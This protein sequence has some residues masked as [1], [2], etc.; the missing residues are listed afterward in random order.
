[1]I[2]QEGINVRDLASYLLNLTKYN[3]SFAASRGY[4]YE[5]YATR[6][7]Q[8]GGLFRVKE[9]DDKKQTNSYK[10]MTFD[11]KD[12]VDFSHSEK[13][14]GAFDDLIINCTDPSK[15]YKFTNSTFPTADLFNPPNNF[16][17]YTVS[18]SHTISKKGALDMCHACSQLD[19]INLYFVIPDDK[20]LEWKYSQSYDDGKNQWKFYNLPVNIQ[21]KLEKIKQFALVLPKPVS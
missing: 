10:D 8:S 1:M 6:L 18:S 16:F 13:D 11:S 17:Q 7:L 9:L 15:I 20:A 21:R 12:V 14:I 19:Q 4:I 3:S 2:Y 5:T